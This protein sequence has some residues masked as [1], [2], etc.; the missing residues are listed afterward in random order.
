[1]RAWACVGAERELVRAL[2]ASCNTPV[3]AHARALD[4]GELELRAWLGLPDGSA[5]LSDELRGDGSPGLGLAV[6]ERLLAAGAREL[7]LEAE[8]QAA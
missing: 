5:W 4:G 6:A 8:K 3:G 1:P 2:G 7:L